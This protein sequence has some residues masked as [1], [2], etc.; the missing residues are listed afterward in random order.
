M[1]NQWSLSMLLHS[2][3][4]LGPIYMPLILL[5]LFI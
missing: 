2:A 5:T 4:G 1:S 3:V